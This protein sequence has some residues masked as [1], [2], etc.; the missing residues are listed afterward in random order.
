LN[1][2]RGPTG[3]GRQFVEGLSAMLHL[4]EANPDRHP[5]IAPYHDPLE[6]MARRNRTQ[7]D[8]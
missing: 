4:L 6:H 3:L 7:D 2:T 8:G 1:G 5:A